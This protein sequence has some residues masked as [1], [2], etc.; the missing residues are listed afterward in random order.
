MGLL[1]DCL[2]LTVCE[3][4]YMLYKVT[5][6][7]YEYLSVVRSMCKHGVQLLARLVMDLYLFLFFL[8]FDLVSVA[9]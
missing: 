6:M 4:I 5:V 1:E 8:A 2:L 7:T 9:S 3:I